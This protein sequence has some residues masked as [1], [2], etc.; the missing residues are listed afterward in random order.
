MEG[1]AV[2]GGAAEKASA[3]AAARCTPPPAAAATAWVFWVLQDGDYQQATPFTFTAAGYT[4]LAHGSA[5]ERES[6]AEAE[7]LAPRACTVLYADHADAH[8]LCC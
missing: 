8:I 6:R 3:A 1:G 7:R 2:E 4:F 5:A